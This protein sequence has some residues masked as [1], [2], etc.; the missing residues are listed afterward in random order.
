MGKNVFNMD[1]QDPDE[2]I[3]KIENLYKSLGVELK[4]SKYTDDKEIKEKVIPLLK[5][6]G[7]SE[8][9]ENNIVNSAIV[10][11]ILDKSI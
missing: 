3:N 2:V 10:E 4:I 9:G 5:K 8:F 6:H 1:T 11:K 7:F